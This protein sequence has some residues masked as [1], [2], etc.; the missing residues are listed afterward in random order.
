M[1]STRCLS[2]EGWFLGLDSSTQGLKATVIDGDANVVHTEALNFSKDLSQFGTTDGVL[3]SEGD[4]VTA[5]SLMFV[6]AVDELLSRMQKGGFAFENVKAISGS[7]QQ[8]GSVYWKNGAAEILSGLKGGEPL[9]G[10]LSEAF[11][12][13]N[14]PI[15]MDSSTGSQ[16]KALEKA[17]G[18][19]QEVAN[20]TGSRAYER[21]TGNQIAKIASEEPEVY[22][23]TERISL[24]S[25]MLPSLLKGSYVGIDHSDAGGMNLMHLIK[26]TWSKVINT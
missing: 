4:V 12:K 23:A 1:I 18:G 3:K 2:T 6:A 5:P 25:S 14:G 7:G 26:K 13:A 22:G 21:F 8:H 10:Q 20:L 19:A 11:S 17:L 15:W 24:V 9:T 16:C